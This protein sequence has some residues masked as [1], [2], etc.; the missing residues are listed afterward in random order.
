MFCYQYTVNRLKQLML[1]MSR[2]VRVLYKPDKGPC[3]SAKFA[4]LKKVFV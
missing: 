2:A 3:V 4:F 1:Y